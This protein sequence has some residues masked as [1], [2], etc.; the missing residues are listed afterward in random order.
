[1]N[2]FETPSKFDLKHTESKVCFSICDCSL[3]KK[4]SFYGL[5]REQATKFLK[6]LQHIEKLTWG[7]FM[8]LLRGKG[9]TKEKR[10]SGNFDLIHNENTSERMLMEQ[11][12]FHFRIEQIGLF[13]IFGYQRDQF[14]CITHIDPSGKINH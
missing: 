8:S 14:F 13:R 6:R 9:A 10:N 11:Y 3:D 5:S 12:Y 2:A 7:Q 1:M 4:Y